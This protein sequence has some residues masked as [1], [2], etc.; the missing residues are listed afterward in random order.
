MY[1]G[2]PPKI[3]NPTIMAAPSSSSSSSSSS[4]VQGPVRRIR[5]NG[6]QHTEARQEIQDLLD[7]GQNLSHEQIYGRIQTITKGVRGIYPSSKAKGDLM[8]ISDGEKSTRCD[9]ACSALLRYLSDDPSIGVEEVGGIVMPILDKAVEGGLART[10]QT[11]IS[12]VVPRTAFNKDEIYPYAKPM[13][14]PDGALAK[15]VRIKI[16]SIPGDEYYRY[17]V[18]PR[19]YVNP[20]DAPPAAVHEAAGA[21]SDTESDGDDA[22]IVAQFSRPRPVAESQPSSSM[23]VDSE[24]DRPVLQKPEKG[25]SKQEVLRAAKHANDVYPHI[26]PSM[27]EAG[28]F[29]PTWGDVHILVSHGSTSRDG[30]VAFNEVLSKSGVPTPEIMYSMLYHAAHAKEPPKSHTIEQIRG[31]VFIKTGFYNALYFYYKKHPALQQ[32]MTVEQSANIEK[33]AVVS[34]AGDERKPDGAEKDEAKRR[35]KQ[36]VAEALAAKKAAASASKDR[37]PKG[38]VQPKIGALQARQ[39]DKERM[40]EEMSKVGREKEVGPY[41]VGDVTVDSISF[42]DEHH[43]RMMTDAEVARITDVINSKEVQGKKRNDLQTVLKDIAKLGQY[44]YRYARMEAHSMYWLL[45][46]VAHMNDFEVW[47]RNKSRPNSKPYVAI[48]SELY[49][50]LYEYFYTAQAETFEDTLSENQ[51]YNIKEWYDFA[52][53]AVDGALQKAKDPFKNKNN[54]DN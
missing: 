23:V 18:G 37:V 22:P 49:K 42:P 4:A 45:S 17:Y 29:T 28:Q 9:M 38:P 15:A 26:G 6:E 27:T 32:A 43:Y 19:M 34:K 14:D 25:P 51:L 11:I 5:P 36:L 24:G 7:H 30:L 46:H 39:D 47:W 2:C 12:F 1:T 20:L 41:E 40:R 44:D 52:K 54:G 8:R 21:S 31:H 53:N 48:N 13:G 35:A 33:W 16:E 50:I 3:Y 10:I